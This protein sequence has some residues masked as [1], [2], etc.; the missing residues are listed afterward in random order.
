[1]VVRFNRKIWRSVEREI[2]K[3]IVKQTEGVRKEA[4]SLVMDTEKT[5]KTY[6]RNSVEHQASAPGEPFAN[7]TGA[8]L[9]QFDTEYRDGGLTGVFI[10][11]GKNA[12][13]LE[14]GTE[15]MEPRP[16]ARPAL[17]NRKEEIE[18]GLQAA[19][20]RGIDKAG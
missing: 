12:V 16:F 18:S 8:T 11:R 19:V 7:D 5:G 1:M 9:S 20:K 14:L 10:P 15:K 6:R 3:E 2:K 13:R 4:I 17:E